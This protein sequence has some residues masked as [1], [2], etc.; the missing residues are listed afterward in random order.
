M[1]TKTSAAPI[2]FRQLL[3]ATDLSPASVRSLPYI[4]GIAQR[5]DSTVFIAHVIPLLIYGVARPQSL[6]AAAKEVQEGAQEKLAAIAAKLRA[7]GI[8]TR[9]L[10]A[11]GDIAL[12]L[13]EWVREHHIELIAVGTTGRSGIRKLAL[14]STAEEIIRIA[15]CAV[16]AVGPETSEE[17]PAELQRILY[18]TDFSAD[19]A[20]AARYA[21]SLAECS[22]SRLIIVHVRGESKEQES[23]HALR[24]RLS[25]L[26]A[27][28]GGHS[29]LSEVL[30]A[31]GN[32][33]DKIIE[34]ANQH[35]A[36]LIVIG[37]RGAGALPRLAS[38]FGSTAHDIVVRARCPVLTVRAPR[39]EDAA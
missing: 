39:S 35:A 21:I 38:H 16:L 31:E 19:S 28:R 5:F 9:T 15:E 20:H 3:V 37:V 24:Q 27:S 7:Q 34:I 36:D 32:P 18:A 17:S 10:L 11:E 29:A 13:P 25:E 12:V 8:E 33:T 30:V 22:A 6:E 14:G 1:T 23:G 4:V 26:V 2:S